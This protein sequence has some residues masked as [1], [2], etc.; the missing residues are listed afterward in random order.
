MISQKMMGLGKKSSVIREIFEYGKKRKAEIGEENVFD[1]SL[2]NPS[3]PAPDSVG[4]AIHA[5]LEEKD[6][7]TLHGYTSA[8]GDLRA[9][10]AV[11]AS[12]AKGAGHA[13]PP[14]LV[15]MTCG[16][17]ASL[18]ITLNALVNPGD[19][20]IV[21][22]PHFPEYRVFAEQAGATVITVMTAPDTFRLD[23]EAIRDAITPKT[24]A[25]LINSPNNPTGVIYP[26]EEVA[27]LGHLMAEKEAEF[28]S[29]LY[30]ISDEP[31]RKL[32]YGI[33]VPYATNFYAKTVVCSSFSK[34]LS[35]PGERIGFILVNPAMPEAG[36]VYAALCGAGR[37][38]GYVCAPSLFQHVIAACIEDSADVAVYAKNREIFMEGLRQ[39]GYR[40]VEPDGAFYLFVKSLDDDANCFCEEAKRHELLLVPSDDFGC[41]G[42]VRIAYCV[43]TEQIVRSLPA[44]RALF[45]SYKSI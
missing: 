5:L 33:S 9:R 38:L 20:V 12:Y 31:Y 8:I 24:K 11:A 18:T 23:L 2:G 43:D 26:E 35:V 1:F 37:A 41:G 44:F 32:A 25:I 4:M 6:P 7:V 19:E 10:E 3:V 28:G 22:A 13:V 15:Y 14:S 21:L 40:V 16:A 29:D 27:A 45:A 30:L 36:D 17:A 34:S 39:I 42:Y